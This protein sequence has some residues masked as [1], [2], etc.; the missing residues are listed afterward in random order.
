MTETP[1]HT[2]ELGIVEAVARLLAE[3]EPAT[4]AE[5]H[6]HDFKAYIAPQLKRFGFE[7]RYRT[8]GLMDGADGRCVLQKRT[9]AALTNMLCG[10]GAIAAMIGQRGIGKTQIAAQYV[11]DRLWAE[12]GTARC[13]WFHYTKLTTVVAKLKAFYGDFGTT[14]M[15][16]LEAYREF[17][18]HAL[19]LLIIDEL[20]EVADDSRHKDRILSDILDARYAAKKDTLLIS[21][22][23]ASEFSKATSP[24]IISRL[25]EHGGI[26]PC[27]WESFR[28]KPAI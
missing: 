15:A 26:I 17:L 11:I 7:C 19:D 25:N 4:E 27:E 6:A 22:Q 8:D 21:N 20:H 13:S 3:I 5:C 16:R 14:D 12:H 10:K 2:G 1:K 18:T 23:S 9:L 28:E 24:S